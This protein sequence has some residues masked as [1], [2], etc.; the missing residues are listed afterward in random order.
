MIKDR[1]N[2]PDGSLRASLAFLFPA[3]DR[4]DIA[5]LRHLLEHDPS[6]A[7]SFTLSHVPPEGDGWVEV[8]TSGL[9]FDLGGLAPAAPAGWGEAAY[10]FG[11]PAD[12]AEGELEA[13][14]L[15]PGA[16]L[17][18]GEALPP[19]TRAML[20]T[21]LALAALPGVRAVAWAPARSLMAPDYFAQS[22]ARWLGGGAFPALGLT[23]LHRDGDAAICSEG[24]RFFT[25]QE[26][27]IETHSGSDFAKAGKIAVRLI[28]SLVSAGPVSS[29]CEV[30]GPEGARLSLEPSADGRWLRVWNKG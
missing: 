23:A 3:G 16:H 15:H 22:V 24:L 7:A 27:R 13:V 12:L 14:E 20:R 8:L 30:E 18:G 25:G 26:L 29:A 11:L 10:R 21:G 4:P 1:L 28:H 9:T 6:A 5:A 2:S 19:V 17:R